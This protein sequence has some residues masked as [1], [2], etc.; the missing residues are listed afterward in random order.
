MMATAIH[1]NVDIQMHG[2]VNTLLKV[3]GRVP[4]LTIN[5]L[6]SGVQNDSNRG[7][8]YDPLIPKVISPLNASRETQFTHS[9]N[10]WIT[11]GRVPDK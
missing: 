7:N 4:S 10:S 2:G 8:H 5:L 6:Y 3:E 11:V 1:L 9:L